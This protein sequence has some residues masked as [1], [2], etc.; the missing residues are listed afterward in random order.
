MQ[1]S[2]QHLYV[3]KLN[4]WQQQLYVV[5]LKYEVIIMSELFVATSFLPFYCINIALLAGSTSVE[6][7]GSGR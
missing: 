6:Q 1:A 7:N 3:L 4:V 2:L 5:T